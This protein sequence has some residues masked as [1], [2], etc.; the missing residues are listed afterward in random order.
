MQASYDTIGVNYA[1]LRR[2]D[3]RIARQIHAAL[4]DSRSV[5][6]VGAGSGPRAG[7]W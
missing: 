2:A 6:N 5:L 4:G 7:P 3:D 1:Q